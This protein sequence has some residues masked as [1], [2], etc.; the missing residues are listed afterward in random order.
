MWRITPTVGRFGA[1]ALRGGSASMIKRSRY[2]I[3]IYEP[4]SLDE[5]VPSVSVFTLSM[6]AA[7][8]HGPVSYIEHEMRGLTD[9]GEKG[10]RT[11]APLPRLSFPSGDC[12]SRI[13]EH[14]YMCEHSSPEANDH[15]DQGRILADIGLWLPRPHL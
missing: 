2:S 3:D 4:M 14:L 11:S 9:D 13:S 7:N 1:F 12:P 15:I 8:Q 5:K 6:L 10:R